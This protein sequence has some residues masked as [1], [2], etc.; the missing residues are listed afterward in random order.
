[1]SN[2]TISKRLKSC[3]AGRLTFS[4]SGCEPRI[5]II[6]Q[7]S[8]ATAPN[9]LD[10]ATHKNILKFPRS[11]GLPQDKS[12]PKIPAKIDHQSELDN[13]K[14]PLCLHF[15]DGLR[16]QTTDH[17][18]P[19]NLRQSPHRSTS[20][21]TDRPS[22]TEPHRS[23]SPNTTD[24]FS[25]KVPTDESVPDLQLTLILAFTNQ[26]AITSTLIDRNVDVKYHHL[27]AA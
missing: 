25:P 1:M 23:S 17:L 18:C 8:P 12:S 11:V 15:T 27:K 2:T 20:L 26:F 22:L 19:L 14:A 13:L 3:G 9:L 5:A 4:V 10:L 24:N 16:G 21:K 7:S 6:V